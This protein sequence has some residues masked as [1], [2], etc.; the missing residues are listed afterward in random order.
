MVSGFEAYNIGSL[1]YR[2]GALVGIPINYTYTAHNEIDKADIIIRGKPVDW[3]S[4]G[5][6]LLEES[7]VLKED[8]QIFGIARELVQLRTNKVLLNSIYPTATIFFM[9]TLAR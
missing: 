4:N 8:E 5:G 1:K 7:L 9:Y 3:S 2:F 6:K